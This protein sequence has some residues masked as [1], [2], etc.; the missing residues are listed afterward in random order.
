MDFSK[1]GL[2]EQLEFEGFTPE[3]IEAQYANQNKSPYA[4]K[5]YR[6]AVHGL[7]IELH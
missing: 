4:S 2:K 6:D 7:Y 5:E 3:E 1:E